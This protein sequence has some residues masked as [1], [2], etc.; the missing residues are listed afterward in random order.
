MS[1]R[2][3]RGVMTALAREAARAQRQ[4]EAAQRRQLREQEAARRRWEREQVLAQK[5][6]RA[7]EAADKN[8]ELQERLTEL[9][10]I[11]SHTLTVDD[12]IA[13]SDLRLKDD[14]EPFLCPQELATPA[15]APEKGAFLSRVRQPNLLARRLPGVVRRYEEALAQANRDYEA[16]VRGH[17]RQEEQRQARVAQSRAEHDQAHEAFLR[18]IEQRN[19]E[20]DEFEQAYQQGAPDAISAYCS[21]VL[22]RSEYPSDFPQEFR[23]VYVPDS[24]ELVVEYELPSPDAIPAVAEYRYVKTRD[25]IDEKPRKATEVKALYQDLVASVA[26]RTVH[27]L[28]EA[29]EPAHLQTVVFNGVVQA[30]DPAT[31]KDIRPCLLSV[32]ASR[33]AFLEIDLA[34]IDKAACLRNLRAQVSSRPSEMLA[35]KPIVE[36]A[37]A[38]RR[39]AEHDVYRLPGEILDAE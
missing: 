4:A 19:R 30:V 9:D 1:P 33:D 22:E 15:V 20:V 7:Q 26:L 13:F 35:V 24:K 31:G 5:E 23:V 14:F 12:R 21:M 27:E 16:A 29:D 2:S 38:D 37:M 6:A 3:F 28:F 18:K 17:E 39:F 34:R 10:G 32:R 11:L 25:A 8:A 36:F